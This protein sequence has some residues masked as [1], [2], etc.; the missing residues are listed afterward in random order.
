MKPTSITIVALG[1][2]SLALALIAGCGMH[3]DSDPSGAF[4]FA[5]DPATSYVQIDRVGMPAVATATIGSKDSYNTASP[6]DDASG[7]FVPQIQSHV[8]ALHTALDDD[9]T[10]AHFTPASTATSIAQAAPLIVPDTLKIDTTAASG[11]PNGRHLTDTVIDVTLSVVL[12]DLGQNTIAYTGHPAVP[13]TA[14]TLVGVNPT[15]NDKTFSATF[16]YLAA[17]F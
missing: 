6:A 7:L 9:L 16:P 2:A 10:A 3:K 15:A 11:F 17:P 12:L 1:G 8:A 4:T 13:Q 5:S 14:T